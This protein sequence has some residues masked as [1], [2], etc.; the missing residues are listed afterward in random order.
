MNTPPL[1]IETVITY[2]GKLNKEEKKIV[3]DLLT[4][5]NQ[6][7]QLSLGSILNAVSCKRSGSVSSVGS[8]NKN[9]QSNKSKRKCQVP[10]IK[11]KNVF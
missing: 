3:T 11:N 1:T 10:N 2:T 9:L 6:G 4:K 5:T 7:P 8:S